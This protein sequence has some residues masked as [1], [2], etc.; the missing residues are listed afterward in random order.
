MVYQT[1]WLRAVASFIDGL[2]LLPLFINSDD[3]QNSL[4]LISIMTLILQRSYFIIGHAQYGQTLGK[5]IMGVKVVRAHQLLPL[6]W[7]HAVWR[8]M[9]LI[10]LVVAYSFVD[11]KTAPAWVGIPL[12]AIVSADAL[13]AWI[14]PRHRSL[15]DFIGKTVVV[16]TSI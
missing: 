6:K 8:E 12:L 9:P 11:V 16:R 4:G 14:H 5:R 10:V 3:Q 7:K 15:R 1:F 2:L 13:I